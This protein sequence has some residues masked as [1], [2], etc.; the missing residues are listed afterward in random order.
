MVRNTLSTI[1]EAFFIEA[2]PHIFPL[3]EWKGQIWG[4]ASMKKASLGEFIDLENLCQDMNKNMHK[5][6][7][8]IYRPITKSRFKELNWNVKQ[9]IK[10]LKNKVS[11]PFD[12]YEI[13]KYD[14]QKSKDRHEM[15]KEFPAHLFLGAVSFFLSIGS[16]Y[17]NRTAYS[18]TKNKKEKIKMVGLEKIILE[19]LLLNSGS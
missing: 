7:S 8:I 12:W 3:I 13:E 15:F 14:S 2:K 10:V 1:K 16:L 9:S 4:F 11:N 18:K 19:N 17:L 6:A 5:V